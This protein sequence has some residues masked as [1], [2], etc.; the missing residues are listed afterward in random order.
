M[1]PTNALWKTQGFQSNQT[2]GKFKLN[3]A[4]SEAASYSLGQVSQM[5]QGVNQD[6]G[7][8]QTL[9]QQFMRHL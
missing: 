4:M 7:Q 8:T 6:G 9:L 3:Q 2:E 5:T 1:R